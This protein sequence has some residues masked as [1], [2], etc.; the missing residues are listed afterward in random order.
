MFDW[1]V[2]TGFQTAN[3]AIHWKLQ[4]LPTA[5]RSKL[6]WISCGVKGFPLDGRRPIH[7]SLSSSGIRQSAV[8]FLNLDENTRRAGRTTGQSRA[9]NGGARLSHLSSGLDHSG[10]ARWNGTVEE[11]QV[12]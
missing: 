10:M 8:R 4:L 12:P 2:D 1:T 6:N 11:E 9:E 7:H 3:V 5:A